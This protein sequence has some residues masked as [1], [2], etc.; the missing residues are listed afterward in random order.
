M[1]AVPARMGWKNRVEKLFP[2]WQG[3]FHGVGAEVSGWNVR[4]TGFWRRFRG[5]RGLATPSEQGFR[6]GREFLRRRRRASSVARPFLRRRR[7]AST[8]EAVFHGVG[9]GGFKRQALAGLRFGR[10]STCQNQ[11]GTAKRLPG[12]IVAR[13]A[14]GGPGGIV[15]RPA[16]GGSG[17]EELR[18]VVGSP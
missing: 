7:G 15:A 5:G 17:Q 8:A 18:I 1:G 14:P 2:A 13:L 9:G 12:I 11:P 3:D 16:T 4:L 10:L 6:G